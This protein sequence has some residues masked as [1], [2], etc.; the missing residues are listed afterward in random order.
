M[1][2]REPQVSGVISYTIPFAMGL[3]FRALSAPFP[4]LRPPPLLLWQILL[5]AVCSGGNARV[6]ACGRET[7]M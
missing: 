6:V 1:H 4:P 7:N 2:V 5:A 3:Q